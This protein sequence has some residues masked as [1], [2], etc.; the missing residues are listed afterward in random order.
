MVF[1]SSQRAAQQQ[2]STSELFIGG[3][4]HDGISLGNCIESGQ[5]LANAACEAL[6]R[7][8]LATLPLPA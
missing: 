4:C 7:S 3:N 5:R 2:S 8:A 1:F 6:R